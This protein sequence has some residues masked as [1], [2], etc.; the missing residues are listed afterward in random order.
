MAAEA[1]EAQ[2][3]QGEKA[4]GAAAAT[5]ERQC[6][7]GRGGG[8][9]VHFSAVSFNALKQSPA[10]RRAWVAIMTLSFITF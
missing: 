7:E 3:A 10:T 2:E 1:P 9:L 8:K 5:E 6:R 4:G